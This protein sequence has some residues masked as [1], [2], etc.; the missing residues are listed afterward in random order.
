MGENCCTLRSWP[1]DLPQFCFKFIYNTGS[2]VW[3]NFSH[4]TI[5]SWKVKR[6]STVCIRSPVN[7]S[8][9]PSFACVW[10]H[11]SPC[12]QGKR[13]TCTVLIVFWVFFFVKCNTFL[14]PCLQLLDSS[15]VLCIEAFD[16]T[17]KI[18]SS[19][20]NTQ[21]IFWTNLKAFVQFI[22]DTEVLAVAASAKGQAYTKLKEVSFKNFFWEGNINFVWK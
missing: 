12:S 2:G 3:R 22:F 21:L 7:S 11:E 6:N 10:L 9:R 20:S 18:I 19:L 1:V 8:F 4:V 16:L 15:E 14:S 5:Y 13:K 17:W